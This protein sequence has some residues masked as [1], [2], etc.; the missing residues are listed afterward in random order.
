M[1]VNETAALEHD[2]RDEV[3]V[4]VDRVYM[5]GLYP[6]R[7]SKE[8]AERLAELARGE[9]GSRSGPRPGRRS[10]STAGR[11]PSAP[12]WRGCAA[13]SRRRSRPCPSSSSPSSGVEARA[14]SSRRRLA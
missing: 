2:L 11:A 9:N 13:G 14:V 6:E 5:N 1:P 10:P 4:A 7:F 8:E 3:G 12:S